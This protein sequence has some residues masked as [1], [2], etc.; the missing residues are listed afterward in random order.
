[1][2]QKKIKTR[3]EKNKGLA[4]RTRK[5]IKYQNSWGKLLMEENGAI[6]CVEI[7]GERQTELKIG[8]RT[9]W[10]EGKTGEDSRKLR[11]REWVERVA[12][13]LACG[14]I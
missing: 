5:L 8:A 14:N 6:S 2:P 7:T 3:E 9:L 10:K 13:V 11:A 1:V 12:L 4:K